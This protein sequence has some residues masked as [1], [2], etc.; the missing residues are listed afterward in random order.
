MLDDV[1][2]R[3]GIVVT[4][5]EVLTGRIADQNG[6]W[7]ARQLLDMGV[8]VA[9]I[10]VCGDRPD[11]LIAQLQFLAAQDVSLIVTTG[12]LGPTADDLTVD[13]VARFTGRPLHLDTDLEAHIGG[14][15]RR[16]QQQRGVTDDSAAARAGT[17]KQAM[18]PAGAQPISPVGT[19]P[20]IAIPGDDGPAILILPGPPREL[21]GMWPAAIAT[22][23][24][25]QA[26]AG[27]GDFREQTIRAMGLSE[28]DLAATL[29]EIGPGIA[30]FDDLEVTTCLRRGEVEIVTR[31]PS[32]ATTS[33]DALADA[34]LAHHG[35]QIFSVDGAT[36]D[37][38]IAAAL[39]GRTIATAESCTG[40]LI[41]ARLTD[42][43]GSS[44]YVAGGVV[45]YSNEAKTALLGVPPE[46][47]AEYGAVSEPV[48]AA[49]AE[50]ALD[51]F[52]ADTALST[53]GIA[54]PGGGTTE[55][56]VGTVCFGVA[57][58]GRPT[59]TRTLHLPGDRAAVRDRSTT[60][61]LHLLRR[62]LAG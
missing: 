20:G 39:Q 34:L 33:Y 2:A 1:N 53:S 44:D 7:V 62:A 41:A 45:S 37:D 50:G 35:S 29:R 47:I 22:G 32:T 18:V 42:R 58:T 38:L 27:R 3:A 5:T 51:R 46:M 14:I 54:G 31:Y 49:M 61:S 16:W 11:D 48:A 15:I 52:G 40:G 56:P 21:Q 26:L 9:H 17:R 30:G 12:G 28:S 60:I 4:G 55:K 43:P 19:A 8:D 24:I 23:P 36:I 13:T 25:E 10:T 59:I 57:L 6:P